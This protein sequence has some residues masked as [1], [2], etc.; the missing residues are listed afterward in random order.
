MP[1]FKLYLRFQPVKHSGKSVINRERM[2]NNNSSGHVARTIAMVLCVCTFSIT[3][4]L[5]GKLPND[6][7]F[8][9]ASA[10]TP[11]KA[12]NTSARDPFSVSPQFM[13][14]GRFNDQFSSGGMTS[15]IERI[16]VKAILWQP[17]GKSI[18]SLTIDG[19]DT[20]TLRVGETLTLS[21]GALKVLS[22]DPDTVV[23]EAGFLPQGLMVL[24]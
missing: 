23:I 3:P 24:R 1:F 7:S 2:Q 10:S 17:K 9:A 15:S 11:A 21:K 20:V 13:T 14:Q 16:K 8:D 12:A 22:I 19:K 4:A 6:L 18:V 5:A